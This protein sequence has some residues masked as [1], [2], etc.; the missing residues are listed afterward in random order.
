MFIDPDAIEMS[1]AIGEVA[2][3]SEQD[4][5]AMQLAMQEENDAEDIEND[6]EDD[7]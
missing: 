6:I 3:L 4:R 1:I 5:I 7:E 2:G